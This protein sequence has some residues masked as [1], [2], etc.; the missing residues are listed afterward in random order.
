MHA[1]RPTTLV[2]CL[3]IAAP[4]LAGCGSGHGDGHGAMPG[5]MPAAAPAS[6]T[7]RAFLNDMTPHHEFAVTM[8]ELARTRAEH[9]QVKALARAIV[10]A[11]EREIAQMRTLTGQVAAGDANST[12]GASDHAMGMDV[13]TASLSTA[14]P[15]DKAFLDMMIPHHRGAVTTARTELAKGTD[16]RVRSLARRII[17]AQ[18]QEIAQ[19]EAWRTRWYGAKGAD[20]MGGGHAMGSGHAMDG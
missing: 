11:Q 6:E 15:F 5:A 4:A 20:A 8:A 14:R 2:V 7:D 19:M 13:D 16:T 9:P 18:D 10:G 17:A 3:L 12:L 1:R